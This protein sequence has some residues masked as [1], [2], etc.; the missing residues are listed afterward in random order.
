MRAENGVFIRNE[1]LQAL[2]DLI[3]EGVANRGSARQLREQLMAENQQLRQAQQNHPDILRAKAFNQGIR[4]LLA[5]GPDAIAEWLD[6]F[7]ANAPAFERDAERA[8]YE[9]EIAARDEQLTELQTEREAERLRPV[10][11]Q[12]LEGVVGQLAR[13]PEFAGVD[14]RLIAERARDPRFSAHVFYEAQPNERP[15][16]LGAEELLL[17]Q[18]PDG[19]MY[20]MNWGLLRDEFAYQAR[21]LGPTR[22]A[23]QAAAHNAAALGAPAPMPGMVPA[24]GNPPPPAAP[25]IPKFKTQEEADAWIKKGEWRNLPT[26]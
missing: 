3:A 13:Q 2:Q 12:S 14:A 21:L 7:Q 22:T 6:N 20:L 10:L 26:P 9:A 19:T 1:G 23:A 25:Q 16:G 5:A 4:N 17:G 11:E 15:M 24:A 18:G 8:V